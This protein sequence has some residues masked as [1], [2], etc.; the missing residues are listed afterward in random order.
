MAKRSFI[1]VLFILL[2]IPSLGPGQSLKEADSFDPYFQSWG[3]T[4]FIDLIN[5]PPTIFKTG[6]NARER[7]FQPNGFSY[8]TAAYR[9]RVNL[10]ELY[11]DL[12]L[13]SS[14]TPAVG[15][16]FFRAGYMHFNL[17]MLLH[18]EIGAKST[19][20]AQ[21]DRFGVVA[22]IG[23]EFHAAP[24]LVS[25]NNI[26]L[27]RG[28]KLRNTW[29]QPVYSI[30]LRYDRGGRLIEIGLK[31]GEGPGEFVFDQEY[32]AQTIRVMAYYFI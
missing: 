24:L 4:T 6:P 15:V 30:G 3:A 29:L 18:I 14:L 9:G 12:A 32:R 8:L 16:S 5:G 26:P 23:Y 28:K 27:P 31:Y 17:P 13:S 22:G 20:S 25:R 7:A 21:M 10:V 11:R 19:R 1:P 2:G